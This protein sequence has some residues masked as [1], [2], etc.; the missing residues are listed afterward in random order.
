[1]IIFQTGFINNRIKFLNKTIKL[2]KDIKLYFFS[3]DPH[4]P[5]GRK[6]FAPVRT[7]AR[8]GQQSRPPRALIFE[9]RKGQSLLIAVSNP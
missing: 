1:M 3:P 6:D 4:P 9:G 7:V 2:V 8:R 5:K